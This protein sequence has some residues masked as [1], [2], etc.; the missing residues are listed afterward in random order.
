MRFHFHCLAAAALLFSAAPSV[1]ATVSAVRIGAHDDATRIVV[2]SSA[3]TDFRAFML[4][5]PP[6]LAIDLPTYDWKPGATKRPKSGLVTNVRQGVLSSTASRII[7][8]LRAPAVIRNAYRM[9]AV[10]GQG[11]RLVVDLAKAGG[12]A[13]AQSV[14]GALTDGK[15]EGAGGGKIAP[16]DH[17]G[18]TAAPVK[19][20]AATRPAPR[21]PDPVAPAPSVPKNLVVPKV[22]DQD[23]VDNDHASARGAKPLIVID[24]GHGGVD[25]GSL[26]V[27]GIFEKNVTIGMARELK[28]EL[29]A[30]GR[31]NVLMTRNDDTFIP[32]GGRVAFARAHHA[33]LFVSLHADSI[34]RPGIQGASIYTLSDKASDE[35]SAKLATRENRADSL[36]GLNVDTADDQVASILVDLVMRDTMNQSKFFANSVVDEMR[37]DGITL[38]ENTQRSAGFAVLKAPDIP[39]VLIEMGFMTNAKESELLMSDN[40]RHKVSAAIVSGIDNYFRTIGKTARP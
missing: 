37:G 10:S 38:L 21:A 6:R 8:D 36:G 11:M 34:S 23:A 39:S 35:Q 40:Y 28:R 13:P 2:D 20:M 16:A 24:P 32:L 18:T 22:R 5:S 14:F 17:A 29:E 26:G 27:G 15:G 31:Y 7:V 19:P 9:P 25:P 12:A 3:K 30:T 4:A 33:N 1:A